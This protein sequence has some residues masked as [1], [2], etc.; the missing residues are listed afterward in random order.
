MHLARHVLNIAVRPRQ[1]LNISLQ[2]LVTITMKR[3]VSTGASTPN[4]KAKKQNRSEREYCDVEPRRA[5]DGSILW[6][7]APEAMK[8]AQDFLREW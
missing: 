7:A 8:S 1:P 4:G 5:G 2:V 3:K 6:P